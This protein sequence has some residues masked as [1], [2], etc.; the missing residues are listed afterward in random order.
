MRFFLALNTCHAHDICIK[1]VLSCDTAHRPI[2]KDMVVAYALNNISSL[3]FML[4]WVEENA[5]QTW[6]AKTC[7]R[8]Q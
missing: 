8:A 1:L 5:N 2:Q 4:Q 7:N 6:V 3:L